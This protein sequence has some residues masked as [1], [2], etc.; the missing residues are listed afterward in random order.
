MCAAVGREL[1]DVGSEQSDLSR[2][3][4]H[5]TADLVEQRGLAGAVRTD[6]QAALA[7]PY[8]ERYVLRHHKSAERLLQVD[9]LERIVGCRGC[10]RVPLRSNLL[11][12][13]TIPVGITR[14]M[15]RNTR[16]S[17]MFHRSTEPET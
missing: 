5:V 3:R 8:C 16:P 7:R 15:N 12:P 10:H 4:P 9:D 1:G 11:K 13:G 17:S 14:T 6:D 2:I